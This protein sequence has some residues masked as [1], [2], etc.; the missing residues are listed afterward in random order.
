MPTKKTM[1]KSAVQS[2]QEGELLFRS[3]VQ[4]NINGIILV[5]PQGNVVEWNANIKKMFGGI[6]EDMIGLKVWE[7]QFRLDREE[8]PTP[9]RRTYVEEAYKEILRTGTVPERIQSMESY[10]TRDDGTQIFV[11]QKVFI[12]KTNKANWLGVLVK[13]LTERKQ[14]EDILRTNEQRYRALYEHTNDAAFMISL[15]GNLMSVNQRAVEMLGYTEPEMVGMSILRFI[16][17]EEQDGSSVK[18]AELLSGQSQPM[19]ERTFI[20]KDGTRVLTEINVAIVFD[21]TGKPTHIQSLA[22]DI[23]ERKQTEQKIQQRLNELAM[24]NAVSQV[25]TSRLEL[26]SM[27]ELTG[28]RLRQIPNVECLFIALL[29]SKSQMISF[30]YYRF[31][32][33]IIPTSPIPL[34]QGLTSRVIENR[35]PLVINQNTD[36]E[37]EKL[38]IVR[39]HA[40]GKKHQPAKSW[41]GIPMQVGDQVIGVIGV[42]NFERMNAYTEDDVRLWETI[43]AN[44]AVAIQNAQLYTAAQQELAERK[45]LIDELERRNAEL[46]RITYILSHELKAPLITMRGFLGYLEND[47]A[48]GNMTRFKLDLA[49][50]TNATDRMNRMIIELIDFSRIGKIMN[51]ME[52]V[53][54]EALVRDAVHQMEGEFFERK[55]AVDIQAGLPIVYGDRQRLLE[56]VQI[57]LDNAAKFMGDQPDPMIAF[58]AQGEVDGKPIFFVKDNGMGI[59]PEYHERIFGL[60]NKL[61]ANSEGTGVGLALVKRIIEFHGGRVWVESEMRKGSTFYF[62]LPKSSS[63]MRLSGS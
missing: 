26:N 49:R 14:A 47:A 52:E 50:I 12:I 63:S 62:T 45:K 36:Q 55:I 24:V 30:P 51:V 29:D 7:M 53:V 34:G 10:V 23:T 4:Q 31:Y 48:T 19:Y 61:D 27:I 1:Q 60:F 59:A 33:D 57:L 25:A 5:D 40:P 13:D 18:L 2:Q 54:F 56:V 20:K 28:E 37:S 58:G 38:G 46:E 9:E 17:L 22:R 32:Q 21:S 39:H 15:E 41:M 3:F 16:A 11:E 8:N 35:K 6:S 43:A 42:Q 44:V